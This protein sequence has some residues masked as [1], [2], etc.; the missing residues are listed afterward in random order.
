[1]KN[2]TFYLLGLAT[3]SIIG[4][5]ILARAEQT[6]TE[7]RTVP[8][9]NLDR[10]VGKWY[11]IA[12]Y[13]NRFQKKC[14]GNTTAIYTKKADGR[15]EVLNSCRT[16]KG[17][18]D[19]AK[20]E[21]KIVDKNTN[22]RLKVR[23]A[24]GFLSFLPFVW[25]DYWVIDLEPDYKYAVVGTPSR[26]YLWILSRTPELDE[27]TYQGILNRVKEQGFDPARLVKT[28]QNR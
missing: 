18:T 7:V 17:E 16:G 8:S 26:D 5:T 15:L 11:E 25:G 24:P 22:A 27:N 3:I 4:L 2:K 13:P 9:V 1:M 20:G 10:Y 6:K 21:A 23:F 14:V 28:P 19:E 12:K